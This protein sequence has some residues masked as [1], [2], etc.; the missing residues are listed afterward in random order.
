MGA[1]RGRNQKKMNREGGKCMKGELISVLPLV[2]M[3]KILQS[4]PDGW[5][6]MFIKIN[7]GRCLGVTRNLIS[8]SF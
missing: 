1:G 4:S 3:F 5:N 8:P 7:K 6:K 2:W